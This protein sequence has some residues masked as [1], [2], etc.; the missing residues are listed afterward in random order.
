MVVRNSREVG[1]LIRDRRK[2][3]GL[4][5]QTLASRAGVSRKWL[6]EVERGK[7]GA[8]LGLVLKTLGALALEVKI[9]RSG[10]TDSDSSAAV[11]IDAV[12]ERARKKGR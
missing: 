12:V 8:E 4:D 7:P 2:S 3:L 10:Q 5:Q 1:A 6:V 11:D 9:E